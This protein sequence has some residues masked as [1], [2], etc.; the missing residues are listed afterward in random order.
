MKLIEVDDIVEVI[1]EDSSY[2]HNIGK[3]ISIKE[4]YPYLPIKVILS[5]DNIIHFDRSALRV[6]EKE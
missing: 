4:V 2:F 1:R 6:L 5:D 3:V